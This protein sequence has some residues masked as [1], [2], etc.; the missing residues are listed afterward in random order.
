MEVKKVTIFSKEYKEV[1]RLQQTAFPSNELYPMWILHFLAL[2]KNVYYLSFHKD[3]EFC[4]LMYY[5]VSNNLVYVFYVAV[6]DKIRSKG[7][8]TKIFEWLKEK[9]PDRE[10]TLNVEPLDETA[11]NAEQRIRRMRFYKKQGFRNS[12]YMLKDSS[13]EFDILT[14]SKTLAISDY[15]KAILNLGMGF[16][17]PKIVKS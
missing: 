15:R 13:G 2:Q 5:L 11:D 6:N 12:G 7:I 9:Y 10:I 17:K 1:K 8:G 4:G 3:S 14:T 16:Y